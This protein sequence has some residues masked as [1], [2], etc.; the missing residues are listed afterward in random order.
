MPQAY[1]AS[2]LTNMNPK[3]A[4][5]AIESLTTNSEIGKAGHLTAYTHHLSGAT[6]LKEDDYSMTIEQ[7]M[8]STPECNAGIPP[9][10]QQMG[11]DAKQ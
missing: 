1:L 2:Q 6:D 7:Q 9:T 8:V 11:D 10:Y 4:A 5:K 3:L